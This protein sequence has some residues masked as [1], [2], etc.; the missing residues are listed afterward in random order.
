MP[1]VASPL[2]VSSEV[3]RS[4]GV[5]PLD[6]GCAGQRESDVF[7]HLEVGIHGG[8]V[9]LITARIVVPVIEVARRLEAVC[10][11]AEVKIE[12][13][14][15][16]DGPPR[17]D[18]H[19]PPAIAIREC[20]NRRIEREVILQPG[21]P[22]GLRAPRRC[23]QSEIHSSRGNN[24]RTGGVR[25]RKPQGVGHSRVYADLVGGVV[26]GGGRGIT[27]LTSHADSAKTLC[28]ASPGEVVARH[29]RPV[30][31]VETAAGLRL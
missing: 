30:H 16:R 3:E 31:G 22:L 20:L 4:R 21:R 19:L 29:R 23:R 17:G 26:V 15:A 9:I 13:R 5:V 18:G 10:G 25:N 11:R 24:E 27:G 14:P 6:A 28:R 7:T 1:N 2:S 8:R 12:A